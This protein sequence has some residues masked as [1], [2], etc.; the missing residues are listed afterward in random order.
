MTEPKIPP[1]IREFNEVTGVIFAQLYAAFP[2]LI[3]INA[4]AVAQ[5]LGIRSKIDWNLAAHSG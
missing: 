4:D 2:D 3:D 5:T 1:N